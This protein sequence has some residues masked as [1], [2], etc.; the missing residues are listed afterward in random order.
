MTALEGAHEEEKV[1]VE[2]KAEDVVDTVTEC[3]TD[4]VVEKSPEVPFPEPT[5]QGLLYF[6]SLKSSTTEFL[7]TG[8][9]QFRSALSILCAYWAQAKLQSDPTFRHPETPTD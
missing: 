5:G 2:E 7:S 4:Y 6:P 3:V 9:F 8:T 1:E